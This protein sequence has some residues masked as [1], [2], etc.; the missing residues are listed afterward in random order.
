LDPQGGTA[1]VQP[2]RRI[3]CP[4]RCARPR[5]DASAGPALGEDDDLADPDA[6]SGAA[7]APPNLLLSSQFVSGLGSSN[8]AARNPQGTL[9]AT[10][11]DKSAFATCP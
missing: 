10:V 1:C 11:A 3:P 9:F 7:S 4:R 2:S 8:Y 5:P 6:V